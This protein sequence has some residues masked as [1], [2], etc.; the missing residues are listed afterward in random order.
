MSFA[1]AP[2]IFSLSRVVVIPHRRALQVCRGEPNETTRMFSAAQ[3]PIKHAIAEQFAVFNR[4]FTSVPGPSWPNHQFAQSATSCGTSSNVMYSACGGKVAQFPQ[5]TIFDS[6][7]LANVPFGIYV[8]DTCGPNTTI[9][10]GDVTPGWGSNTGTNASTGLD[11]DVTMAGV[12]V[13]R[14][15]DQSTMINQR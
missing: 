15:D 4:M 11:P 7:A 6:L 2:R 13:R 5:M 14:S 12:A 9:S 8:N 10:C 3:L 1:S